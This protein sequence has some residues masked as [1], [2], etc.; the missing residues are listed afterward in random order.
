MALEHS[1]TRSQMIN[2]VHNK[3]IMLCTLGN[4]HAFFS[5]DIF[6]NFTK[7]RKEKKK[8]TTTVPNSLD[9]DQDEHYVGSDLVTNCLQRL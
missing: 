6:L 5:S 2:K 1:Q 4:S 3:P 8:T 9:L 7:K